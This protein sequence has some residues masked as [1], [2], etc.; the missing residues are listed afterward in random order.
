[1]EEGSMIWWLIRNCKEKVFLLWKDRWEQGETRR[2]RK[3]EGTGGGHVTK[4]DAV[5]K[6]EG[7]T[8]ILW[9]RV[10]SKDKAKDLYNG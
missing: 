9:L 10:D 5:M 4:V 7:E 3:K 1:M 8:M 6:G 2:E